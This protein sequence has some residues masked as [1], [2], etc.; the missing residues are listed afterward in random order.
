MNRREAL[1]TMSYL[2][3]ATAAL[4]GAAWAQEKATPPKSPFP[5]FAEAPIKTQE[6]A[7]GLHMLSGPGGNIA[8]LAGGDGVAVID[9]GVAERAA[10]I[11]SAI[12]GLGGKTIRFLLNTH[13]HFDHVG[14]NEAF[15]KTG[16]V[17][18]AHHNVRQR[19]AAEQ[20]ITFVNVKVPPSPP[21]ALPVV[22]FGDTGALHH[23]D[24]VIE[25]VYVPA[26]HTDTDA[27][28]RL[29]GPDV[30]HAGDLF[31]NGFYPFI[32]FSTGG[33]LDGLIAGLD[34]VLAL[35]GPE[36]RVIPGHGPLARKAE[37]RAFRDMLA[38]VRDR[39]NPLVEGGKSLAEVV[40]AK[41]TRALDEKWGKGF[42][43]G[44]FF[45]HMLYQGMTMKR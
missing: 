13:W 20:T 18:V 5:N 41:P 17:I 2:G 25:A 29:P 38:E 11:Q 21:R 1:K 19:M 3:A 43:T 16:A 42:F 36:T 35:V 15:A 9:S 37:L 7:R 22:T 45:I 30:V 28:Y 26:A 6:L 23:E 34:R 14:G 8:V 33:T 10:A 27:V 44:D 12:A 4:G 31:F 24:T 39:V 32:D 40:A